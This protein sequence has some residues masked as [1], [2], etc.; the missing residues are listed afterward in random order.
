MKTSIFMLLAISMSRAAYAQIQP[1]SVELQAPPPQAP[2]PP[3][4]LDKTSNQER[5]GQ[6]MKI[7]G[8]TFLG[9]GSASLVSGLAVFAQA[10]VSQQQEDK[11]CP[12]SFGDAATG[13][14]G[15]FDK[16]GEF[17]RMLLGL[18]GAG[19]G[20][21]GLAGGI[22]LYVLGNREVRRSHVE[23]R[24]SFAPFLAPNAGGLIA[25]ASF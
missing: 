6:R 14:I 21:L 10:Y 11:R 9:V 22:T 8:A 4:T 3:L 15:H 18:E 23:S 5:T 7:A 1:T 13:C 20:L 17:D 16:N 24:V 2:L 25:R 19:L 12:Q